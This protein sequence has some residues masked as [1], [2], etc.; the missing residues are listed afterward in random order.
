VRSVKVVPRCNDFDRNSF[1]H[2]AP[3]RPTWAEA[4]VVNAPLLTTRQVTELVALSPETVLRR[5]RS[6]E[7]RGI[8]LASN[9][10]RFEREAVEAWLEAARRR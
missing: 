8:R 1:D 5:Y 10:L 9:V 4:A 3:G 2:A 7:L 6:G